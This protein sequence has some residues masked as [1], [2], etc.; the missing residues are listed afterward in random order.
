MKHFTPWMSIYL[1]FSIISFASLD[2]H[3]QSKKDH[4]TRLEVGYYLVVGAYSKNKEQ[5]AKTYSEYLVNLGNETRYNYFPRKNYYFVYLQFFTDFNESI[6][7]LYQKRKIE[8]FKDCWIYVMRHTEV[9]DKARDKQI[10]GL[11]D[12]FAERF[13]DVGKP[14]KD[15]ISSDNQPSEEIDIEQVIKEKE[16]LNELTPTEIT[17]QDQVE[18]DRSLPVF[19]NIFNAQTND[20][21]DGD[22]EIVDGVNHSKLT[23]VP[24]NR[25][26]KLDDPENGNGYLLLICNVFGYKKKQLDF[27]YYEPLDNEET[28]YVNNIGDTVVVNFELQRLRKGDI[29]PMYNVFFFKDATVMREES[30]Y[31]INQLLIMLHENPNMRITIHGHTNGNAQ[32]LIKYYDKESK[33]YFSLQGVNNEGM[34]SAKK[35]SQLR[36]ETIQSYLIDNDIDIKRVDTK[37]W[38]GKQMLYDKHNNQAKQNVRVEIEVLED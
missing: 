36:A 12:L 19:M 31:E 23:G 38:G 29:A 37:G 22:V 11:S 25:L 6:R 16:I 7:A 17:T 30:K 18:E 34:G 4:N 33:K 13:K 10:S 35:L 27:Y 15:S 32:G 8:E 20:E 2:S 28:E 21:I 24:G 26:I 14:K 9:I 3:A 5:Y 1:I